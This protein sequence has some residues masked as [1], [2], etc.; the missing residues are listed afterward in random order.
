MYRSRGILRR[1][2]PFV[3]VAVA[4]IVDL[5]LPRP[6]RA[7][8]GVLVPSYFYP[9]TGG[10]GGTGDGWAQMAAAAQ[11]VSVTAIFNPNSGPGAAQDP[12]YAAAMANLEN[13]GGKVIAYVYT[14]HT[15]VSE[16]SVEAQI[17]AYINQY[18]KL[19][20]GFFIDGMTNDNTTS[21]VMYYH[22][23]YKYIKGLSSSYQV[24]GNPGTSTVPDYLAP[25][26]QGA[27]VLV[28]YENDVKFYQGTNP[29][30]WVSQ[31][32]PDHFANIMYD[33]PNVQNMAADISLAVQRNVGSVFV[34]N[35]PL[36][37][38]TGYLYDEL[39]SY[40]NQEIAAV[41]AL[42]VPE[43]GVL[44]RLASAALF[45]LLAAAVR[46]RGGRRVRA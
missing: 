2:F 23:M 9:G 13:A 20:N 7:S 24:V 17:S 8:L 41:A 44:A 27:D 39:P 19:I 1:I 42:S 46:L 32:S 11:D 10:A 4:A 45:C 31:Y 6:A 22:D 36:N 5:G 35:Q 37:P 34:T 15:G 3:V 12:N 38:S 30:S 18:G 14:N 26:T 21:N 40:W 25:N 29:P 33:E 43:P 16:A 28:T